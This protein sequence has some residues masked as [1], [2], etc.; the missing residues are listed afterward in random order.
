[1]DYCFELLPLFGTTAIALNYC[2]CSELLPSH[3]SSPLPTTP[4]HP[5]PPL[6]LTTRMPPVKVPWNVIKSQRGHS[7][8]T[9]KLRC[10][11]KRSVRCRPDVC[12]PFVCEE[13]R[14]LPKYVV[15]VVV[16]VQV[17][18]VLLYCCTVVLLLYS[19]CTVVVCT[20]GSRLGL[21]HSPH[22]HHIHHIHTTFTTFT[23]HHSLFSFCLLLLLLPRYASAATPVPWPP[24]R[25]P[26][27]CPSR[28]EGR[29]VSTPKRTATWPRI[30]WIR[31][32]RWPRR[33]VLRGT[34][35]GTP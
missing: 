32:I 16:V 24:P 29:T 14:R 13:C 17:V 6:L 35:R 7:T 26:T 12:R 2:H 9:T 27:P 4:H 3:H 30:R 5:L 20:C 33:M 19:C 34:L 21:P 15:P 22:S 25:A 28:S 10:A 23:T 8:R 31:W 11:P 18:V 1:M